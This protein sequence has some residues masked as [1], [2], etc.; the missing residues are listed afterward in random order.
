MSFLYWKRCYY[1]NLW[2]WILKR[3][4][5]INTV[6]SININSLNSSSMKCLNASKNLLTLPVPVVP[7]VP[8][9]VPVY[10]GDTK[11]RVWYS[12]HEEKSSVNCILWIV[13]GTA[14]LSCISMNYNSSNQIVIQHNI[15]IWG[16]RQSWGGISVHL[17]MTVLTENVVLHMHITACFDLPSAV[18]PWVAFIG[19]RTPALP[20]FLV[21]VRI[22]HTVYCVPVILNWYY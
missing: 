18:L 11:G 8:V 4:S 2:I 7:I 12:T 17:L 19:A 21:S 14:V 9:P 3:H 6:I 10:T 15:L 20:A 1:S 13:P 5:K 16:T 22:L